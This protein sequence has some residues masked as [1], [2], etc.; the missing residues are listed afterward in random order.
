MLQLDDIAVH[1][2][3]RDCEVS[4]GVKKVKIYVIFIYDFFLLVA[5]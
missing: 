4:H 5:G 3:G 1:Q 2:L